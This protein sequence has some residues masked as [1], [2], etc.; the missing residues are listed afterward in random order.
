MDVYIDGTTT[1]FDDMLE[2]AY[3][4]MVTWQDKT[5]PGNHIV[6]SER[7]AYKMSVRRLLCELKKSGKYDIV[8]WNDDTREEL[9]D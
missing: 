8:C 7:D 6:H 3:W 4:N 9:E 5:A 1:K 2:E